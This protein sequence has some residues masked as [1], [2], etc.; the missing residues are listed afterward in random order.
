LPEVTARPEKKQR[1]QDKRRFFSQIHLF[2]SFLTLMMNPI[3]LPPWN[4][5]KFLLDIGILG[6]PAAIRIKYPQGGRI[7]LT[8]RFILS[9]SFVLNVSKG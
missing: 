5:S 1:K 9:I 4:A 8:K 7:L 2:Y 6:L 3:F